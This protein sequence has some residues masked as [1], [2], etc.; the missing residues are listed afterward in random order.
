MRQTFAVLNTTF[1]QS[2]KMLTDHA[3]RSYEF[4][5]KV[6]FASD[7]PLLARKAAHTAPVL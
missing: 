7:V 5:L 4:P 2:G 3:G 1:R 6:T